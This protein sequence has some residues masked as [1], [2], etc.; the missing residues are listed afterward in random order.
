MLF[1]GGGDG[2]VYLEDAKDIAEWKATPP[3]TYHQGVMIPISPIPTEDRWIDDGLQQ[4]DCGLSS[5]LSFG[6]MRE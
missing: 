1:C 6:N 2:V 3:F 5:F 4:S